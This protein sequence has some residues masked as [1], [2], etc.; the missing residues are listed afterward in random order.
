M[1]RNNEKSQ[2]LTVHVNM[3]NV[4]VCDVSVRSSTM[5]YNIRFPITPLFYIKSSTYRILFK[6]TTILIIVQS[7]LY[8]VEYDSSIFFS[9]NIFSTKR[10]NVQLYMSNYSLL[11]F[12]KNTFIVCASLKFQLKIVVLSVTLIIFHQTY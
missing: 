10:R 2:H 4:T 3:I 9:F 5:S 11:R 1:K 6:T 12:K 8:T 7:R